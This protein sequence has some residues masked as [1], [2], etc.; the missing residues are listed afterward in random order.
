MSKRT[1]K[2]RSA[3]VCSACGARLPKWSGQCPD[4]SAWNAVEEIPD[5][6]PAGGRSGYA[7]AAARAAEAV[8]LA[9]VSPRDRVRSGS[10]IDELDRVLGGGLVQGSVV[11]IGGDPGIGK[12]TCCCSQY[13]AGAQLPVS[14]SS[15]EES[16]AADQPARQRLGLAVDGVSAAAG[17]LCGADPGPRRG[18][19]PGSWW[20][21]PSRPC[22]RELLAIGAGLRVPGAGAAAQLVRFAK[23]ADTACSWSGM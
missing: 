8:S 10:G 11:L 20:W 14:M 5:L 23:Q 12:S 21:I 13:P 19:R 3:Y 2:G 4:C 17:D 18:E 22:T 9:A 1:T 16:P 15:G 7:G 6:P